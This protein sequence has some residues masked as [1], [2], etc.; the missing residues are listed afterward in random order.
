MRRILQ[1]ALSGL[2]S[3]VA[4]PL[5]ADIGHV[6]HPYIELNEREIEYGSSLRDV[7]DN[8]EYLENVGLG[9]AFGERFFSELYVIS[10]A[11][12]HDNKKVRGYELEFKWQLTEQGEYPADWGFMLESGLASDLSGDELAAGLLWEK[13]LP[14]RWV[15][16]MNAFLEYEY[17]SDIENEFETAFRGQLRYRWSQQLEPAFEVYL[18]DLDH[19]AGPAL[20]GTQRFGAGRRFKWELGWMLGLDHKTPDNTLRALLEY[21]F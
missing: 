14:D 21:E 11:L 4:L 3:L 5:Y 16:T 10:E 15:A 19:A 2:T 18:D 13:E 12:D 9:Y 7:G 20:T 8:S 17:G 6:Y 1:W